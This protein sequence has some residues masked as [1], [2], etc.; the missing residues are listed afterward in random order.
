MEL[1]GILQIICC[2]HISAMIQPLS[3]HLDIPVPTCYV[4]RSII[5][6][7]CSI[8]ISTIIQQLSHHLDMPVP[9]CYVQRSKTVFFCC[10]TI[11]A[12]F[13]QLSG[14]LN[15]PFQTSYVQSKTVFTDSFIPLHV[16]VLKGYVDVVRELLNHGA[17]GNTANKRDDT[18]L[19]IA[20]GN[21]YV[22][23]V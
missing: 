13:Q 10:I 19:Y 9:I 17:N 15:I 8:T 7:I 22:E 3:H 18:P 11:S 1:V 21:G 23:V 2:I 5:A 16:A 14:H 4:Q 12:M 6:F 20:G